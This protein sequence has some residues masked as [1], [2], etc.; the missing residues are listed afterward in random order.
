MPLKDA[1]TVVTIGAVSLAACVVLI[2]PPGSRAPEV[3]RAEASE[4]SPDSTGL[5]ACEPSYF[6]M[7]PELVENQPQTCTDVEAAYINLL[8]T[9]R[10]HILDAASLDMLCGTHENTRAI[11]QVASDLWNDMLLNNYMNITTLLRDI[12]LDKRKPDRQYRR[13]EADLWRL[14][15]AFVVRQGEYLDRL[16]DLRVAVMETIGVDV[17]Q[18]R[19]TEELFDKI[20]PPQLRP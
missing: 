16:E 9:T 15:H 3:H 12:D 6:G 4:A 18:I 7:P 14:Y 19:Q 17:I 13:E 10:S 11:R 5:E 8:Q 2:T 20:A 1:F